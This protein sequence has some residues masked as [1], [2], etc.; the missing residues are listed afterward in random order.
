MRHPQD[1][2]GLGMPSLKKFLR[3][4]DW[5]PL[6]AK[7][8]QYARV[9]RKELPAQKKLAPLMF[10]VPGDSRSFIRARDV[11][12]KSVFNGP[13]SATQPALLHLTL[14]NFNEERRK[15]TTE[16][17]SLTCVEETSQARRILPTEI[18]E[19]DSRPPSGESKALPS[20]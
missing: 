6:E 19:G 20:G 5:F 13:R 8:R 18:Q 11:T 3:P 16:P 10:R 4:L 1:K 15:P 7:L 9:A 14:S 12:L 2:I 17:S